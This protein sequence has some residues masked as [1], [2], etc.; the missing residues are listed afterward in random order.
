MSSATDHVVTACVDCDAGREMGCQT[1]C[2]RLLVRLKPHEMVPNEEGLAPKGFVD[3][4]EDGYCVH[5]DRETNRCGIWQTRPEI[6][7]EY[8]C[9]GDEVLQ[10]VL[11]RFHQHRRCS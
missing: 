3:K 8:D 7:R 2:C 4:T 11:R 5:M 1:F 9:N 6:C 10:V